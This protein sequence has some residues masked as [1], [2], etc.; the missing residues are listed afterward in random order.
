VLKQKGENKMNLSTEGENSKTW[1]VKERIIGHGHRLGY[2]PPT[3]RTLT[4]SCDNIG[5]TGDGMLP[6]SFQEHVVP[7]PCLLGYGVFI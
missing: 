2:K 5:S 6:A 7:V 3:H 4:S 1:P